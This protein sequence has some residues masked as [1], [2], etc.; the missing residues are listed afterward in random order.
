MTEHQQA[1]EWRKRVG[2]TMKGLADLTGY[3]YESIFQFEHGKAG[4]KSGKVDPYVW[5]RYK[6]TC[7]SVEAELQAG[8]PFNWGNE[9]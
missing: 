1:R 4:G 5:Q 6:R 3:S 2:L 9:K 8:K 7:H